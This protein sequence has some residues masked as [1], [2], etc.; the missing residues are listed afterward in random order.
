MNV[1]DSNVNAPTNQ[2]TSAKS[3]SNYNIGND[4][5]NAMGGLNQLQSGKTGMERIK[6]L[7]NLITAIYSLM[8]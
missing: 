6:G 7:G 3:N 4:I 8:A 2:Q 5:L 1:L